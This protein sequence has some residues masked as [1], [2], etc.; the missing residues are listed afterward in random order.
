MARAK[1]VYWEMSMF[2]A[3]LKGETCHGPT[4]QDALREQMRQVESRQL[5]IVTS[6][7]IYVELFPSRYPPDQWERFEAW[8][9]HECVQ[10]QALDRSVARKAGALRERCEALRPEVKVSAI[11]AIHAATALHLG[12]TEFHATDLRLNRVFEHLGETL[13]ASVPDFLQLS[14]SAVPGFQG[15]AQDDEEP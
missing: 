12:V 10:I 4:F 15:A 1:A 5:V 8:M 2:I 6:D 11:D 9:Q 13:R 3:M 7:V 14:M